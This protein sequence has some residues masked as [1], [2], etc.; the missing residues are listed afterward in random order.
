MYF[1]IMLQSFKLQ[2]SFL[3]KWQDARLEYLAFADS[4]VPLT[5]TA[6]YARK[7]WVP[8]SFFANSKTSWNHTNTRPNSYIKV[9]PNGTILY[10][11]R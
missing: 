3:Q 6:G 2:F 1:L 8:D 4:D 10:N 7:I 9:Y 5:L 11:M